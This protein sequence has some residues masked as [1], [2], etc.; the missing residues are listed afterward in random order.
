[1]RR[2]CATG[3]WSGPGSGLY[4]SRQIV[5]AHGGTIELTS[6]P[7][8]GTCVEILLPM[9]DPGELGGRP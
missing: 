5:E 6:A 3:R 9:P 7:G 2:P 8:E 4:L 1:M